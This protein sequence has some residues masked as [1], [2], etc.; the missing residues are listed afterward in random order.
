[1]LKL[2]VIGFVSLAMSQCSPMGSSIGTE[3]TREVCRAWAD[4]L[5]LPSREDTL[6][7]AIALNQAQQDYE[8]ACS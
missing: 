7:T 4:S 5:I 8:A 1:M 3:T 6:E 2:S